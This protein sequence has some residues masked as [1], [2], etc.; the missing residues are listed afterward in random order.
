LAATLPEATRP[1]PE[2]IDTNPS[3]ERVIFRCI[4]GDGDL[5]VDAVPAVKV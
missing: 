3:I 4:A 1:A 2:P 5:F